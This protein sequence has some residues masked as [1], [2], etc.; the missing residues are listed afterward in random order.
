[1]IFSMK[2]IKL[3]RSSTYGTL[4]DA[5]SSWIRGGAGEGL[6]LTPCLW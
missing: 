6:T 4:L 2:Q 3:K 5:V 1:M